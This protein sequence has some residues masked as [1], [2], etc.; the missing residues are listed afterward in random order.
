MEDLFAPTTRFRDFYR[1]SR[2]RGDGV[3]V[4]EEQANRLVELD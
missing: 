2:R 3:Y 1:A 4:T